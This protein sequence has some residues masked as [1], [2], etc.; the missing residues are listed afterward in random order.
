MSQDEHMS[1]RVE[2]LLQP[3][4]QFIEDLV[5]ERGAGR[6]VTAVRDCTGLSWG[7]LIE[8]AVRQKVLSVVTTWYATGTPIGGPT[9]RMAAFLMECHRLNCH[10]IDVHAMH[11]LELAREFEAQGIAMVVTK[12]TT[13]HGSIYV[14][15]ERFA[16]SDVDLLVAPSNAKAAESTLRALGYCPGNYDS[17]S[18]LV[19]LD[20]KSAI[21]YAMS[22]DHLVPHCRVG[23]GYPIQAVQVD[24]ALSV[25]WHDAP[26]QVPTEEVLQYRGQTAVSSGVLPILGSPYDLI[27]TA[28]HMYREANKPGTKFHLDLMKLLDVVLLADRCINST[29]GSEAFIHEV[30]RSA[31]QE[32]VQWAL[33]VC[34]EFFGTSFAPALLGEH[35]RPFEGPLQVRERLLASMA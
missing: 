14:V 16:G 15:G 9:G 27:F 4:W 8:Y 7:R 33:S 32:P 25:T 34:D 3:E 11:A 28:L 21:K 1:S 24:V 12:G 30:A 5:R 19:E 18:R 2:Q 20:R 26:W 17:R 23:T 35:H 29:Q 6:S 13:F 22:P 31:L 10:A